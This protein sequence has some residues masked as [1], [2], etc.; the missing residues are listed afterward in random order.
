MDTVP[1]YVDGNPA[2]TVQWYFGGNLIDASKPLTRG[3]SGTY[4]AVAENG[5]GRSET[6]VVVK[7][8]CK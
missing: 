6:S 2:V 3:R 5:L 7:V 4:K 8:E 1:C